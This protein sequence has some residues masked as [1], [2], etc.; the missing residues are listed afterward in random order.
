M[1]RW[2]GYALHRPG[3]AGPATLTLRGEPVA[4]VHL[5]PDGGHHTYV[6]PNTEDARAYLLFAERV[7]PDALEADDVLTDRL[8]LVDRLN[9]STAVVFVT[10]EDDFYATGR[11]R[12]FGPNVPLAVVVE[13]LTGAHRPGGDVIPLVW[14]PARSGF[15]PV[16]DLTHGAAVA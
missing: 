8:A 6:F 14:V 10:D 3:G 15:V 2:G 13:Q 1:N 4:V 11:Y 9:Q 12:T 5:H 16:T 7:W